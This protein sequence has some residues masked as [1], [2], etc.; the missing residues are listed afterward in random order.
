[1]TSSDYNYQNAFRCNLCNVDLCHAQT[2]LHNR[3]KYRING[4]QSNPRESNNKHVA[5][6]LD[7]LTIEANEESFTSESD[8]RSCEVT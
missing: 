4:L 3:K 1:M 8:L 6:M 2:I 5:T 7:E